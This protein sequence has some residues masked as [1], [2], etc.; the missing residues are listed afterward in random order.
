[1]RP[2]S[3]IEKHLLQRTGISFL[4][5]PL[6]LVYSKIVLYKL[7]RDERSQ[8]K[9]AVPLISIGNIVSGGSGKTP[10]TISLIRMLSEAGIKAAV[11]HRGYKGKYEH[12]LHIVR[13]SEGLLDSAAELGDEAYMLASQLPDTPVAVGKNRRLAV[14]A[15][16]KRYPETQ[17]VILDDA[18][19]NRKLFH[20]LEIVSFNLEQGLGNGWT[21]PAG[22]LREPLSS[23]KRNFVAV[24]NSKAAEPDF[25]VL[26][27]QL[28]ARCD[29]VFCA[30][31][32]PLGLLSPSGDPIALESVRKT[33]LI[34]GIASPSSFEAMAKQLGLEICKHFIYPDHYSYR[35]S[36]E[37]SKITDWCREQ[38]I[39]HLIC[40]QKDLRKLETHKELHALLAYIPIRLQFED[41]EALKQVVLGVVE[42]GLMSP[43]G[44]EF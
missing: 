31:A 14:M 41:R 30:R 23:L 25:G 1:M 40:T 22:Y 12:S 39:T 9:A 42:N 44:T 4:L 38:Q 18:L 36:I 19:Q 10:L 7:K 3:F 32:L 5:Y 2:H 15:L 24:I 21:I 33:A 16:L 26:R 27:E 34:S 43:I 20:D 17:V 35:D 6:S 8:S 37:L 28:K 11:S 13:G 29:R